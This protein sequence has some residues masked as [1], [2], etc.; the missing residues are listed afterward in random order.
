MKSKKRRV[1]GPKINFKSLSC[2]PIN[3]HGVVYLFGVLHEAFDFKIESVQAGFPDCIARREIGKD[4]WEEIRIEF[5][6]NSRS[7]LAHNHDPDGADMI[8]C[9]KHDWSKCPDNIEV[10]EL[11]SMI[12]NLESIVEEVKEPKK[13]SA[14]N[15]FC[16]QKRLEGYSF[17]DISR[18]W[19]EHKATRKT[20]N[21]NEVASTAGDITDYRS[22]CKKMRTEGKSFAEIGML[23][24]KEKG[25]I[26][27][28]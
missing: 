8:V 13:L 18:L 27:G 24:R 1:F 17:Q 19:G 28:K 23:W 26:H 11:S 15:E 22:F 14:Y 10:I 21:A 20:S 3:E 2:A 4:R 25:R 16:R 9:W 6:F 12:K 5:E 7:F